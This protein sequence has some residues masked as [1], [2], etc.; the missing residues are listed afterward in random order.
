VDAVSGAESKPVQLGKKPTLEEFEYDAAKY[1]TAI[2]DWHSSKSKIEA[3]QLIIAEEKKLQDK[4]WNDRLQVYGKGKDELKLKDYD[5]AESSVQ[6]SL[7]ISKQGM[8][9]QGAE[10]P[11]LIVYALGKNPKKLKELAAINDPVKFSFAVAKLETK[12]K[13]TGRKVKTK[14]EKTLSGSAGTSGVLGKEL[15]NLRADAEKSGDYTKV[16]AY[17]N[18]MRDKS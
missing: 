11:A 1:E 9:I 13:V 7:S 17:N 10:N 4:Q 14:P 16:A 8:I 3:Q 12:L 5:E 6:D 15:E 18:K 2:D